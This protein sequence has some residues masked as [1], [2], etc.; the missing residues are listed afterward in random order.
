[1]QWDFFAYNLFCLAFHFQV[2]AAM[3]TFEVSVLAMGKIG[4]EHKN[5]L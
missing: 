2:G 1:M 4:P 5:E 3:L